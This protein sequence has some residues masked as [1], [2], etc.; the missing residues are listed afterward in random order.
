MTV[1]LFFC[2]HQADA[3]FCDEL[4]KHLRPAERAQ[5]IKMWHRRQVGPGQDIQ[6]MVHEK[7]EQAD[8]ILILM[9]ADL[10]GCDYCWGVEVAAA[11]QRHHAGR[12]R[13]VPVIVR[14]CAW[15]T[16]FPQLRPIHADASSLIGESSILKDDRLFA[17][18]QEILGV[19][20][21]LHKKTT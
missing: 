9:S 10:L 20:E 8:L 15:R 21:E 6:K 1:K 12:A 5:K 13:T 3:P 19:V 11:M 18:A 2:H 16:C 4:A 14:A 7:L 17:A